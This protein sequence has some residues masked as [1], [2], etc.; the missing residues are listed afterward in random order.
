MRA[1]RA[2]IGAHTKGLILVQSSGAVKV[3]LI[4]RY[5]K[6]RFVVHYTEG[7]EKSQSFD[8]FGKS[9]SIGIICHLQIKGESAFRYFRR[10]CFEFK[11]KHYDR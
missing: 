5:N 3:R 6:F 10:C 8:I 4:S 7:G 11:K 9:I 2:C 1:D